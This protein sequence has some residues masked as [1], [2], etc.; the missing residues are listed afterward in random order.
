MPNTQDGTPEP[1]NK[2]AIAKRRQVEKELMVLGLSPKD[3][4]RQLRRESLFPSSAVNPRDREALARQEDSDY[5]L[6]RKDIAVITTQLAQ[7]SAN[8]KMNAAMVTAASARLYRLRLERLLRESAVTMQDGKES[9]QLRGVSMRMFLETAK[10][11]AAV[12]GVAV[13]PKVP[14]EIGVEAKLRE[15]MHRLVNGKRRREAEATGEMEA[16]GGE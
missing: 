10:L 13:E 11:L 8:P 15:L 12:E 14:V 7:S 3:I 1:R 5:R 4:A 9:P 16:E 6:V 2:A